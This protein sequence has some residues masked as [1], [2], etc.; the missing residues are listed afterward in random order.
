MQDVY[1]VISLTML[2]EEWKRSTRISNTFLQE[3][4]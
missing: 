2:S 4:T 1:T 3:K